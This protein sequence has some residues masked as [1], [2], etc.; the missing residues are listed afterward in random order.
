M[1]E[2]V[3]SREEKRMSRLSFKILLFY[4]FLLFPHTLPFFIF[5]GWSLISFNGSCY[6]RLLEMHFF[7]ALSLLGGIV[8]AESMDCLREWNRSAVKFN[9]P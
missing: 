1:A 5:F 6:F 8:R 9:D 2:V 7:L 3:C 4:Y